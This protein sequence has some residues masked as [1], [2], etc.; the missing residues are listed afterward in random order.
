MSEEKK[1]VK[2][3]GSKHWPYVKQLDED[4]TVSCKWCGQETSMTGTKECD[5]CHEL[6]VRIVNSPEIAKAMLSELS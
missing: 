2:L 1:K 5:N 4:S 6:R 3:V